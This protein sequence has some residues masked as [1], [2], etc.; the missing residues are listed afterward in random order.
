MVELPDINVLI[1]LFDP[2]H[3]HHD[4]AQEW[5]AT[6]SA[7]GWATCPLTENGFLRILS[8]PNYANL[9]LTVS[10][11]TAGLRLLFAAYPDSHHF[12]ADDISLCDTTL[13]DLNEVQGYRQLT[14]LYL[15]GLCQQ[16][17]AALVTFDGGF[18][19]L[20]RAVIAAHSDL[21]RFLTA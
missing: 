3:V 16:R 21:V 7:D 2:R 17:E 18:Q 4:P 8:N 6:V 12:W 9:R 15:L 1:A 11:V 19:Q 5:F 10:E 20:T 14:D 13:F